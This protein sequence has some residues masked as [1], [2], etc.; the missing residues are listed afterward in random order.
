MKN[1]EKDRTKKKT[2]SKNIQKL[3]FFNTIKNK[4]IIMLFSIIVITIACLS[5]I[6]IYQF[7]VSTKTEF[8]K[9]SNSLS[10]SVEQNINSKFTAIEESMD[11]IIKESKFDNSNEANA[12]IN[13][14]LKTL[15]EGD[16]NITLA[17]FYNNASRNLLLYPYSDTSSINFETRD[18]YKKAK[19]LNGKF[20]MTN[21]YK[22]SISNNSVVTLCKAVMD[23]N[24]LLGIICV[25]YDLKN[26]SESISSITYGDKGA[27]CVVD[28]AGI[29][30]AH[31]QT[32]LIGK[33]EFSDSNWTKLSNKSSG[34]SDL[35]IR[36]ELYKLKYT[37]SDITGWKIILETPMSEYTKSV[38][39]FGIKMLIITIILLILATVVGTIFAKKLDKGIN[40]IKK[41]IN[42]SKNGDFSTNISVSSKDELHQLAESF[43]EM[44][45]SVSTLIHHV[46]NSINEVN[47]SS[48]SLSLMSEDVAT[49]MNEVANTITEISRGSMESA[50]NL[51]TLSSNLENV[52][53][54]IN[55]INSASNT[56]N[57]VA[58]TT[59]SLSREGVT[60]IKAVMDKSTETK[61]STAD[62]TAVVSSVA[63]SVKNIA[64]MNESISQITEQTNLLALNAAIEAAR[65]GDAG[66]GFAVVADE[67]RKLAEETAV[68][69]KDIDNIIMEVVSKVDL[70]VKQV[71]DTNVIVLSQEESVNQAEKIFTDIIISLSDL[72]NKLNEI[73][74]GINEVSINKD[75][76]VSEVENVSSIGEE[77]AAGT[78]EVTASTEEV[79]A[80]SQEFVSHANKLKSLSETLISEIN[81]F[82]L[83]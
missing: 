17:Y 43:N 40:A 5:I 61:N 82:K 44:Q 22:D 38:Y 64:S 63:E 80:S 47:N 7:N 2:K 21:I 29:I 59:N 60:I 31:S 15:N 65:A 66:K 81:K 39:S 54:Q 30:L 26:L 83:Q 58:K 20:G 13:T 51:E 23:K 41:G 57:S 18:W 52:S 69:A 55:T 46:D 56:I 28:N 11:Y 10:M 53:E 67:I 71:E 4:I 72:T 45:M 19:E 3:K 33:P 78:E 42:R 48:N 73:I 36:N 24:K 12:N 8:N 35:N 27:I 50:Q 62:V 6:A 77:T 70:A 74:T 37:T 25:D 32:D 16:S 76:I 34:E 14:M 49:S 68:S 9:S 1:K 79:S 75:K